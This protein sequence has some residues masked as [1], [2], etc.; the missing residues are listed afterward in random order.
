MTFMSKRLLVAAMCG[1]LAMPMAMAT[2]NA[3]ITVS[4]EDPKPGE[5]IQEATLGSTKATSISTKKKITIKKGKK[6]K[7]KVTVKPAAASQKVTYKSSKK[8]VVKVTKKGVIKGIKKGTAKITIKT[9][10]GSNKK[11]VVKVTVK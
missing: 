6:K 2:V 7:L 5:G 8:K 9:T 3:K 10:D 11:K 1:A 4:I